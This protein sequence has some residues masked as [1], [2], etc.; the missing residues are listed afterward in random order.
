MTLLS[1]KAAAA[2]ITLLAVPLI[3]RL[4]EPEHFGVAALFISIFAPIGPIS[5]LCY[6][7]AT[8]LPKEDEHAVKL[9]WLALAILAVFSAAFM[10]FLGLSESVNLN[11]PFINRVG[12]WKWLLPLALVFYGLMNIAE[13]WLVRAKRFKLI[14]SA[15]VGQSLGT[16]FSRLLF[17]V[18]LGSSIGA[19]ITGYLI[20]LAVKLG[21]L[22]K[23]M[24]GVLRIKKS[25]YALNDIKIV[26]AEYS[27]FPVYNAPARFVRAFAQNLPILMLGYI[28]SPATAGFYAMANR[29]VRMPMDIAASAVR[30]TY[31]Q[32][33]TELSQQGNKVYGM[34]LKITV[35]LALLGILPMALLWFEGQSI[36]TWL[37]GDRWAE[38]G[39]YAQLLSPWLFSIWVTTPSSA[40]VLVLRKQKLWLRIQ[41]VITAMLTAV[42]FMAYLND[43]NAAD[44][45]KMFVATATLANGVIILI[46]LRLVWLGEKRANI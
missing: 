4:F 36:I 11:I 2:V 29:L 28:F 8:I 21:L 9:V 38:A 39:Y 27:D 32:R 17:G 44:T 26:A 20:G 34:A 25:Q 5:T 37:L 13:N 19:L 33:A 46:I 12:E 30:R 41:I 23:G 22:G 31:L 3:A 14:A 45:L 6:E 42:F 40:L 1:G 16:A 18:L 24:W 15:D 43:S 35:A 7:R 10:L